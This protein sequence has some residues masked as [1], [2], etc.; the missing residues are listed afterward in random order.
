MA[1]SSDTVIN[2]KYFAGVTL[3]TFDVKHTDLN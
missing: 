1:D 2:K 3:L